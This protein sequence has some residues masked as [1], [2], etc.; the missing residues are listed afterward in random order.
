LVTV[1]TIAAPSVAEA[2]P[3]ESVTVAPET[4]WVILL[5]AGS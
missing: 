5:P 1:N 3:T 4:E 2:L